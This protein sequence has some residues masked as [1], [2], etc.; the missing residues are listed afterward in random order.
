MGDTSDNQQDVTDK[1]IKSKSSENALRSAKPSENIAVSEITPS[2]I[3][4]EKIEKIHDEAAFVESH[5][6]VETFFEG[7]LE[8]APSCVHNEQNPDTTKSADMQNPTV[9]TV[10]HKDE[11][12]ILK[13]SELKGGKQ[14]SIDQLSLKPSAVPPSLEKK[15]RVTSATSGVSHSERIIRN[16]SDIFSLKEETS[17]AS[18]IF[19]VNGSPSRKVF[20]RKELVASNVFPFGQICKEEP[21]SDK[22]TSPREKIR[23]TKDS[24]N[25]LKRPSSSVRNPLTGTG[26][27]SNDEYK[28]KGAKRK[29]GNPLLGLGYSPEATPSAHRIPPGGFSHKLW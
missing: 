23:D 10:I 21:P 13:E 17:M 9:D 15:T 1:P 27:S 3:S 8:D 29:D 12:V 6:K 4:E 5:Q 2:S 20:R 18:A 16:Q 26:L 25:E 22:L 24:Y 14:Q 19:S 7:K 28:F 11:P